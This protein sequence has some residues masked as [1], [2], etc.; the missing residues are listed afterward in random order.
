V[1]GY[2]FRNKRAKALKRLQEAGKKPQAVEEDDFMMNE[3][4]EM[5]KIDKEFDAEEFFDVKHENLVKYPNLM[6]D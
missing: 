1:R 3:V 5:L 2:L 6:M 4:D